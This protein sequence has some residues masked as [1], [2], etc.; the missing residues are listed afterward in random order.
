MERKGVAFPEGTRTAAPV[1]PERE[2]SGY[3]FATSFEGETRRLRAGEA[4]WDP[5]T[6]DLL[7]VEPGTACL[8]IGGG[9]GSVGRALADRVGAD[10]EVVV[11]DLRLDRVSWLG[12]HGV[13]VLRHDVLVDPLPR[14]RFDLVHARMVVQHLSDQEA[15]V[16]RMIGALR[17]GGRLLL[18]DTDTSS[19]FRHAQQEGFLDRVKDAAYVIMRQSGHRARGGLLDLDLMLRCGLEDVQAQGRAVVVQGGTVQAEWYTLWI[20]HL[21]P[22]M[23]ASGLVSAEE[24]D[25]ALEQLRDPAHRWLSQVMVAVSGRRPRHDG[26]GA[27]GAR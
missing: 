3:V 10:G 9:C 1:A 8:E 12:E 4:M 20:E 19:L 15:A 17:P 21:R 2:D 6:L 24:V 14:E 27:R 13:T 26:T 11:T 16:R 25:Q 18:E 22:R 7:R 23:E 5:G